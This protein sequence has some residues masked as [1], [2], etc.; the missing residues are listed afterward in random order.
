M[1]ENEKNRSVIKSRII[2]FLIYLIIGFACAYIYR[3]MKN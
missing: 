2:K 3:Q 1:E